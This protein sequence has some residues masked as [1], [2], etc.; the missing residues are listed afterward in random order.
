MPAIK[1]VCMQNFMFDGFSVIEILEFNRKKQKNM[2]NCEISYSEYYT[3]FTSVLIFFSISLVFNMLF[4]FMLIEV[5][6]NG[7]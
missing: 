2:A 4:T 3:G 6:L 1:H 7:L 5:K